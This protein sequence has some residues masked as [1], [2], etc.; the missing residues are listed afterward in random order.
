[1]D[2]RDCFSLYIY[3][4]NMIHS[5]CTVKHSLQIIVVAIRDVAVLFSA[6]PVQA[7]QTLYYFFCVRF[8]ICNDPSPLTDIVLNYL[9]PA[10][11][12]LTLLRQ[13]KFKSTRPVA[14][15]T[16]ATVKKV[17]PVSAKHRIFSHRNIFCIT[18]R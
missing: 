12:M 2:S 18:L 6:F 1:M 5:L 11:V 14:L 13:C 16:S 3:I 15:P 7:S 8:T 10:F 9:T 4:V 17:V